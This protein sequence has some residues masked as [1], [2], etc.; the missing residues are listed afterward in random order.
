MPGY[1]RETPGVAWHQWMIVAG[2]SSRLSAPLSGSPGTE[3]K[4]GGFM[5]LPGIPRPR[6]PLGVRSCRKRLVARRGRRDCIV[7]ILALVA[8]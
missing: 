3:R 4:Q 2:Y 5:P 1:F 8:R 7:R 6:I